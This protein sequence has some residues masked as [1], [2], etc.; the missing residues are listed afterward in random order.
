MTI[1]RRD[2]IKSTALVP[3]ASLPAA[4][5]ASVSVPVW[6]PQK[7]H[8]SMN[9]SL[10]KKLSMPKNWGFEV[11]RSQEGKTR[12]LAI[13]DFIGGIELVTS[14][15]KQAF[16]VYLPAHDSEGRSFNRYIHSYWFHPLANKFRRGILSKSY[17]RNLW[18]AMSGQE[19]NA[20]YYLSAFDNMDQVREWEASIWQGQLR[21]L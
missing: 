3:L 1:S 4:A 18:Y 7:A 17:H 9:G 16:S 5:S 13:A 2:L 6:E 15:E 8:H 14:Y 11:W 20:L 12:I 21:F 10:A 19:E